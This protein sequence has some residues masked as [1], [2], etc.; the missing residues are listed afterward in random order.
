MGLGEEQKWGGISR[1]VFAQVETDLPTR[2]QSGDAAD[3]VG[4]PRLEVTAE[5]SGSR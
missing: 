3:V 4:D 5:K 2:Q 1:I